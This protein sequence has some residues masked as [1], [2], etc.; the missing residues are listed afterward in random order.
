M[1]RTRNLVAKWLGRD[2]G[3]VLLPLEGEAGPAW[4]DTYYKTCSAYAVP[5]TESHYYFL[6]AVIADRIRRT[7]LTRVLDIGC[8]SGQLAEC[9]FDLAGI[10]SYT[11]LD[12]SAEAVAMARRACPRGRFLVGD[13][14]TTGVHAEVAHDVVICTEVLEHV[15]DD[16]AVLRR[17]TPSIRALCT[18]PNFPYE[19]HVRHFEDATQVAERYAPFFDGLDVMTLPGTRNGTKYFLMDGRISR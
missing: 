6:W 3:P 16:A 19:S 9:L 13:A 12:F 1:I 14:R 4:Y 2:D 18:V 10:T 5:Y 17:F 11:G 8:G 15:E 7:S